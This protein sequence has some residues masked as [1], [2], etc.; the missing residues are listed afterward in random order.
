[1]K[2][3]KEREFAKCI[4]VEDAR[5]EV[6]LEDIVVEESYQ[7]PRLESAEA[8]NAEWVEAMMEYMKG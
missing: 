6:K 5:I 1:M 3:H 2:E 4:M 8:I 7:G